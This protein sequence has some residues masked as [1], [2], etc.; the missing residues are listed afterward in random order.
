MNSIKSNLVV[1]Y[2]II[3][4]AIIVLLA[5]FLNISM[6]RIFVEYVTKQQADAIENVKQQVMEL[7]QE[8]TEYFD[9]EGIEIVANAA[10]QKG[11]IIR[12]QTL[13]QKGDW[14]MNTHK[15]HE[16]QMM[17]EHAG[18]NMQSMYPDFTGGY[19]EE[20]HDLIIDDSVVGYLTVG[21]YGPYSLDDNELE[22]LNMINESL[23]FIGGIFLVIAV[24]LGILMSKRITAPISDAVLMAKKIADG[25]Y[26]VQSEIRGKN[27]ETNSLIMAINE[28]S[29][30]LQK[31]EIQKRQLTADVAHELRT[32][33]S[34]LQGNLEAM[35]DG[36]W[37]PTQERLGSCHEEIVRL[38]TIV[39][40]MQELYSLEN[41]R[42]ELDCGWIDF[43]ELCRGLLVDF[44][45]KLLEKRI[46]LICCTET[47]DVVWGDAYRIR[48]CMINLI[49]NAVQYSKEESEV[50]IRY[51]KDEQS[52]VVQVSDSGIGIPKEELP[53]LFER[54]YRVDKSRNKR[55]GGMG[56]GLSI[57]KAIVERHG[58]L[59]IVE[60]ELEKGTTF[61][62]KFPM[63]K[64]TGMI[65]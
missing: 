2:S 1:T 61:T 51:T 17:L 25:E 18:S 48:Q 49:A 38:T 41:Q 53:Y 35:L 31:D 62:M 63:P 28:M 20:T 37:E 43:P 29:S 24:L 4:V 33:L 34:N 23:F 65:D 32:P 27:A 50:I 45:G 56:I 64:E 12:I 59:I 16:S 22:M 54:F 5:F 14:N 47:G 57:T 19:K 55:T 60:S 11:L 36:I 42:E 3:S 21:Y 58:G 10:L 8:E 9:V 7:Y 40:Q 13:N 39:N 6:N 46:Q 15:H 44:S 30:K 26:G 52:A